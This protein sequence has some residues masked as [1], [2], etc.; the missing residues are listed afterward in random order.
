MY[1]NKDLSS[2]QIE[3]VHAMHHFAAVLQLYSWYTLFT[4]ESKVKGMY[5]TIGVPNEEPVICCDNPLISTKGFTSIMR[6]DTLQ[7]VTTSNGL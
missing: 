4:E 3:G 7:L 1:I 2:S 6:N 5:F